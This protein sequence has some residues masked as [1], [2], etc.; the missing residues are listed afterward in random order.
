MIEKIRG[1]IV[2]ETTYGDTSKIINIMTPS[3]GIVGIMCKG[4]KSMKSKLRAVTAKYTYGDFHMYYKEGKLS[5]LIAVDVI[6]EFI[7]LKT[8]ITLLSYLSYIT[9]LS[10]QVSKQNKTPETFNLLIKSALKMNEGLNPQIITNILEIKLLDFLGVG[11]NL[12]GCIKCGDTKNIATIDGS[13]GGYVCKKCFTNE[14]IVEPKTIQMLR[15]YYYVE[16]N[17]ITS[18]NVSDKISRE[19]EYFLDKYYG[20]FTGL[21]LKSKEFLKSIK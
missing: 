3:H 8:D 21:Y 12:N 17:S 14:K 20:Q 15:M 9:D 5:V 7:N 19:I 4:V 11:L 10:Y 6:D 2:S 18:I 13:S 1:I 16:L